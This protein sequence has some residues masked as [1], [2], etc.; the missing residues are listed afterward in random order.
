MGSK[1]HRNFS[2]KSTAEG[3]KTLLETLEAASVKAPEKAKSKAYESGYMIA[4]GHAMTSVE[5]IRKN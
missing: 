4:G 5:I 2:G 1:Y 3:D